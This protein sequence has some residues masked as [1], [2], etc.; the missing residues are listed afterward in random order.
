MIYCSHR[1]VPYKSININS[2]LWFV[3]LKAVRLATGFALRVQNKTAQSCLGQNYPSPPPCDKPTTQQNLKNKN[4]KKN[5]KIKISRRTHCWNNLENTGGGTS[6]ITQST[7]TT[8]SNKQAHCS[9]PL[10]PT[11]I[12]SHSIPSHPFALPVIFYT[13]ES[14]F[15]NRFRPVCQNVTVFL[16]VTPYRDEKCSLSLSMWM[17]RSKR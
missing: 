9:I 11:P 1:L 8:L 5:K 6:R 12:P 2:C 15:W 14:H 17:C 16:A 13:G 10:H 4:N 3:P 7:V